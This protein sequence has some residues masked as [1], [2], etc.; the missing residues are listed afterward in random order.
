MADIKLTGQADIDRLMAKQDTWKPPAELDA[1][2]AAARKV[3]TASRYKD[4]YRELKP[5]LIQAIIKVKAHRCLRDGVMDL[6]ELVDIG[7]YTALLM[8]RM[9]ENTN[10]NN[11]NHEEAEE[12]EEAKAIQI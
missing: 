10:T 9:T 11:E 6:E 7:A 1:Y 8:L 2:L 12:A 4:M 3:I 5:E